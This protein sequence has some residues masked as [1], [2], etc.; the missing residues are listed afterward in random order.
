MD[1]KSVLL[2]YK[3]QL[4]RILQN[5]IHFLCDLKQLHFLIAQF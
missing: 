5:S 2:N 1:L 4:E 3:I